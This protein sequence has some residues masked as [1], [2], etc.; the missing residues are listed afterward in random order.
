MKETQESGLHGLTLKEVFK[1]EAKNNRIKYRQESWEAE[2]KH[3][4]V[5]SNSVEVTQ[6][7]EALN[8]P[9]ISEKPDIKLLQTEDTVSIITLFF[10][11]S[12]TSE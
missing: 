2:L 10:N 12:T 5:S 1:G 6:E 11:R 4:K 3:V 7:Q 9:F 8:L